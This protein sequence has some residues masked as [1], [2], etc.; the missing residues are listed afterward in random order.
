MTSPDKTPPEFASI[1]ADIELD[2]GFDFPTEEL[3]QEAVAKRLQEACNVVM[4]Y[5][6]SYTLQV[7]RKNGEWGLV[8]Q[9]KGGHLQ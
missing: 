2:V 7:V 4:F 5:D 9:K 8:A 1:I 6:P 3:R